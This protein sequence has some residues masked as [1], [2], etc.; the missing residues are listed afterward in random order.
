MSWDL[1]TR[2]VVQERAKHKTPVK[3]IKT[4]KRKLGWGSAGAGFHC[5]HW[6]V[7]M[8]ENKERSKQLP[9][10]PGWVADHLCGTLETVS[11]DPQC[12]HEV[13]P[14]AKVLFLMAFSSMP[15]KREVGGGGVM[16][17]PQFWEPGSPLLPGS[18]QRRSLPD[19]QASSGDGC[20]NEK[21]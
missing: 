21:F 6:G 18:E 4:G 8:Q 1:Y 16:A 3:N 14:R 5:Q 20:R 19:S 12:C 11:K 15:R 2:V 10:V 7:G 17:W 9:Q 13:G